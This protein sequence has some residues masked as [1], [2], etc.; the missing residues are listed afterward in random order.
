[1]AGGLTSCLEFYIGWREAQQPAQVPRGGLLDC[2]VSVGAI[3]PL[4]FPVMALV[5]G[6]LLTTLLWTMWLGRETGL[7]TPGVSCS[8]LASPSLAPRPSPPC[9]RTPTPTRTTLRRRSGW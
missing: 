2:S 3:A 7:G 5:V 4:G 1:V 8:T 9:S 6:A